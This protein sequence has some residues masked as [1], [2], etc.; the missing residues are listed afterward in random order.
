MIYQKKQATNVTPTHTWFILEVNAIYSVGKLAIIAIKTI[1]DRYHDFLSFGKA[2][3]RTRRL[4]KL[5]C[6][7]SV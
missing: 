3:V 1:L 2:L 7:S 5:S 4:G 6:M